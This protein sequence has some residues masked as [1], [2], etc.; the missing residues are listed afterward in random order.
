MISRW[1]RAGA[2]LSP[3]QLRDARRFAVQIVYQLEASQQVFL[4]ESVLT[5]FFSQNEVAEDLHEYVTSAAQTFAEKREAVD[6]LIESSASNWKLSRI[7]RVDLAILRICTAEL[8]TRPEVPKDVIIYEGVELGKQFGST[9]SGSF[10]NGVLDNV[11]KRI[12][13]ADGSG[14]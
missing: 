9:A 8:M 13:A 2:A 10:I 7:A 6:M 11:A 14:A 4:S 1:S 3:A 5:A 12:Q